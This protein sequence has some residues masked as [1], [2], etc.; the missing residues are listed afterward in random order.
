MHLQ[1]RL[2]APGAFQI[3]THVDTQAA[4]PGGLQLDQ[5]AVLEGAQTAVVGA[6]GDDIPGSRGWIELIHSMTRG[7]LWAIS[8][9]L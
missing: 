6:C 5:I 7:I 8:L 3:V 2:P 4:E 9:V 1:P